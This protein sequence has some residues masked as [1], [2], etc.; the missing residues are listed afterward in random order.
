MTSFT[1][2]EGSPGLR[3][4][5]V[6]HVL[7][8]G[9][10]R[11]ETGDGLSRSGEV[12]AQCAADFYI[13]QELDVQGGVVVASGYKTP[14]DKRGDVWSPEDSSETFRGIPEA[15]AYRAFLMRR[16]IAST[17][18][19]V[20]PHSIDTVTNFA[21][22]EREGHF[23]DGRPAAIVGQ[24]KHLERMLG[25]ASKTLKR[26][27][28]GVV[29][30]EEGEPEPDSFWAKLESRAVLLG[31]HPN[32]PHIIGRTTLLA[33]SIWTG[34]NGIHATLELR[35]RPLSSRRANA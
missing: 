14:A 29:V 5:E 28:L 4:Y 2:L 26:D 1:L 3:P 7:L 18:I 22:S 20:E 32:T 13:E 8:P 30:P 23:P 21:R 9:R 25:I 16:G 6:A 33:Q 19:R 10:G 17:A 34:V 15:Y 12:R 35:N 24:E 27:F 31:V 11:N